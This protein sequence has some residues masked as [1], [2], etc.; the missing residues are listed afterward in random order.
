MPARIYRRKK[1][2]RRKNVRSRKFTRMPRRMGGSKITMAKYFKR[3]V[4][5]GQLTTVAATPLYKGYSFQLGDV[6][7]ISEFSNLFDRYMITGVKFQIIFSQNVAQQTSATVPTV[8]LGLWRVYSTFD[9]D[10]ANTPSSL[11]Y[12][13]ERQYLKVQRCDKDYTRYIRPR[14]APLLYLTGSTFNPS[15]AAKPMWIDLAD[16]GT[17]PHYGLKF[18]FLPPPFD[19]ASL[20]HM[21]ILVTYYFKCRDVL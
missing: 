7:N 8:P 6:S 19:T 1:S 16:S 17:T 14:V 9:V 2:F 21:T 11:S 20:L 4:E 10:D 15:V 18:G 3:S 12:L 5:L 13:L